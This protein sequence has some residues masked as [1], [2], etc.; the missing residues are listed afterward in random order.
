MSKARMLADKVTTPT[1]VTTGTTAARDGGIYLCR[2]STGAITIQLPSSGSVQIIDV[3][4]SASTN[5]IT[6]DP[7]ATDSIMDGS[8]DENMLIDLNWFA[9]TFTRRPSGTNWSV[10]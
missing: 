6:V 9:G 2:T 5:N 7:P 4:G 10:S 3:D 8:A 1:V